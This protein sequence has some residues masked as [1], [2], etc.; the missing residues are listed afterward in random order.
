MKNSI[1]QPAAPNKQVG[2][3]MHVIFG[4]IILLSL[5]ICYQEVLL[6]MYARY[7]G[8]DSYYSHGFLIPFVSAYFIWRKKEEL[9]DKEI[10][11]CWWGLTLVAFALIVN[12]IGHILYVFSVSG[13]SILFLIFKY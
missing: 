2:I 12:F 11:A 5:I 4:A 10:K 8:A 9:K 7:K 1:I 6:W 3:R 13:F